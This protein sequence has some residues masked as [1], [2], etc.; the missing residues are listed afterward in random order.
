MLERNFIIMMKKIIAVLLIV[1]SLFTVFA[2]KNGGSDNSDIVAQELKVKF[3]KMG[4][5]SCTIFR[6]ADKTVMIDTGDEEKYDKIVE[7]MLE[8]GINRIDTLIITS[9]SKKNIGGIS[10]VLGAATVGE[11]YIPAYTKSSGTYLTFENALSGAGL[12]PKKVSEKTTLKVSELELTLYPPTKEYSSASDINDEANSIVIEAKHGATNMLL[13]SKINGDRLTEVADMFKDN[14]YS[15]VTVP[16]YG[17]Y[18]ANL[19]KLFKA[20]KTEYAVVVTSTTNPLPAE[21]EAV[22][23]NSGLDMAKLFNTVN[24]SIEASSLGRGLSEIKN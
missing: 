2:C 1:A 20:I 15:L 11:V 10:A 19:E 23:K 7:Y 8:K 17:E 12:T 9:L 16:N 21:T 13:T 24:G 22:L 3:F 5:A 4:R 6:I 14:E 18:D